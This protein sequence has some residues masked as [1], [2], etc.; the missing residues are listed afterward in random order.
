MFIK[1]E[2]K[3]KEPV[4]Y[5][6][7]R[8]ELLIGS[9]SEVC[10]V[11]IDHPSVSKKHLKILEEDGKFI[12]IDQGSTNGT[13]LKGEQIIPGKRIEF[14]PEM[15]LRLGLYAFVGLIE[16]ADKYERILELDL[17][18]LSSSKGGT[19]G[20]NKTQLISMEDF[21]AAKA[22]AQKKKIE[23]QKKKKSI[24]SK[25][26][27]QDLKRIFKAMLLVSV[28]LYV[29]YNGNSF[30]KTGASNLKKHSAV[31]K[32]QSKLTENQET[33]TDIMGFR[34][35]RKSLIERDKFLK[36]VET[37]GCADPDHK[38]YCE[39]ITPYSGVLRT[40]NGASIF[41]VDESGWIMK[42]K[43]ALKDIITSDE[44]MGKIIF[45]YILEKQDSERPFPA[46]DTFIAFYKTND[47]GL[48]V[49]T[50]V[51]AFNSGYTKDIVS[52]F[53]KESLQSS[54]EL[55]EML[56]SIDAYINIY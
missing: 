29:G 21:K 7:D 30:F 34:V 25:K 44:E 54:A 39:G 23:A 5:L 45:L 28:V 10:H 15:K 36:Y 17:N 52:K 49:L 55:N 1:V 27:R 42:A 14:L 4:V 16:K 20:E 13:Y 6:I 46:G 24:E 22:L 51:I 47:I 33:V 18:K 43:E 3:S 9:S 2:V 11:K 38:I 48:K 12:A 50:S 37:V 19:S 32:L 41:V 40:E 56:T 26:K 8:K 35:E 53:K 31:T